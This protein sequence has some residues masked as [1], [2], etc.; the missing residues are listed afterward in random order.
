M[1]APCIKYIGGEWGTE[2]T[3]ELQVDPH[4]GKATRVRTIGDEDTLARAVEGSGTEAKILESR[5][6]PVSIYYSLMISQCTPVTISK[7]TPGTIYYCLT[8][9][10]CTPGTISQCT[11]FTVGQCILVTKRGRNSEKSVSSDCT[12]QMY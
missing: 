7:C 4:T 5:C 9:S 1:S 8:I 10:K 6:T 12:A 11:L 3:E 2:Y